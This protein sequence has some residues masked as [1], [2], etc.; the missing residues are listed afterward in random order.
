MNE[1]K[2]GIF[3]DIDIDQYHK[4]Q[5]ISSSGINLILE[6]PA[7]YYYHYISGNAKRDTKATF[8]GKAI[9][10]L[11]LEPELFQQKFVLMPEG[12]TLHSSANKKIHADVIALGK[13]PI[14]QAEFEESS[15][16]AYAI[17]HKKAF[18]QAIS[19]KGN[20][21]DSIYW[22]DD[23]GALLRARP[24]FYND[25]VIIDIKSTQSAAEEDFKNSILNYGYH[26]QAALQIDGLEKITGIKR[27]FI[28]VAVEKDPPYLSAC[29]MLDQATI[30]FGRSEYK[31]GSRLYKQCLEMDDWPGYPETIQTIS[32]PDW[33]LRKNKSEA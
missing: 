21:E 16:I 4:S 8:L 22:Q 12:F 19:I 6:S 17:R 23:N 15:K 5:G 10:L 28:H 14:R 2:E 18:A 3:K 11:A 13:M 9:H 31:R 26:I 7:K 25:I 33:Y 27:T 20:I 29:Y 1:F 24:D 32:L 30:D